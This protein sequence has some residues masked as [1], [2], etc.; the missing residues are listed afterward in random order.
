MHLR[1]R[2]QTIAG[3][4]EALRAVRDQVEAGVERA[5]TAGVADALRDDADALIAELT[6]VEAE[7]YQPRAMGIQDLFNFEPQLMSE[8]A[9]VYQAVTGPDGYIAGGP[10]RQPT[11]GALER[12]EY[13]DERWS[14]VAERLHGLL[15]D[16]VARVNA[17]M[18]AAGVPG[19]A[20]GSQP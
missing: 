14:A 17:A 5:E 3:S 8:F 18:A 6:E 19:V 9:Q 13:L 12:T 4:I 1:D 20:V 16:G 2:M 15:T 7:L 11:A 10:D